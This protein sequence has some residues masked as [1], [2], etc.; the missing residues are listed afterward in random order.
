ML[1]EQKHTDTAII[2]ICRF[3][4]E[5]RDRKGEPYDGDLYLSHQEEEMVN[6]VINNFKNVIAVINAEHRPIPSGIIQMIRYPQFYMRGR[7]EWKADLQPLTFFA[8]TETHRVSWSIH[9]RRS[10]RLSLVSE[11]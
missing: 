4:R 1:K 5:A 8:E 6:T 2:T 9:L 3:S 11:L 7:E 10:F